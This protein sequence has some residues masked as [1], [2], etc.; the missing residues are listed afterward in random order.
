MRTEPKTALQILQ[1]MPVPDPANEEAYATYCLL[2]VQA[3]DKDYET[4]TSDSMINIAIDYFSER[5]DKLRKAWSLYYG[6]RVY[7]DMKK[8]RKQ[9]FII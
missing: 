2:L 9:L 8:H 5:G 1:N 4:H 6:G 3:L 7:T